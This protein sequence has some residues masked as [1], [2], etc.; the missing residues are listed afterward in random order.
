MLSVFALHRCGE[1]SRH[2]TRS[3][4]ELPKLHCY[5]GWSRFKTLSV[6]SNHYRTRQHQEWLSISKAGCVWMEPVFGV[7]NKEISICVIK[8]P[9]SPQLSI[10]S[11]PHA[12]ISDGWLRQ[13]SKWMD[14]KVLC[15]CVCVCVCEC[16]Q[17]TSWIFQ[18]HIIFSIDTSSAAYDGI[19]WRRFSAVYTTRKELLIHTD[20][21]M[22]A[23]TA[24][25]T[26]AAGSSRLRQ[27]GSGW[28][29]GLV[30][31]QLLGLW[32]AL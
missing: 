24:T 20:L 32:L 19:V 27:S 16:S 3:H 30:C 11:W 25:W 10:W 23:N 29:N 26:V 2:P 15:V 17:R 31:R 6:R 14:G 5:H 4:M 22:R 12:V 18:F 13:P 7:W 28:G 8:S 1:H 21:I 9:T